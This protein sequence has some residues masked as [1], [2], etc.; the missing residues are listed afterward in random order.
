MSK[1]ELETNE[2]RNLVCQL[3]EHE[4]IERGQEL[5]QVLK[6]IAGLI[7]ERAAVNAKIKPKEQRVEKLVTIIDTKEE[8][9][10]V[11]CDWSFNWNSG[12][13]TLYRSDTQ[14]KLESKPITDA[15]RQIQLEL[16]GQED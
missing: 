3:T 9:R 6:D 12:V 5:D 10:E 11:E 14:E 13:K 4:L 7:Q 2:T 8:V 1:Q 15:E 16:N